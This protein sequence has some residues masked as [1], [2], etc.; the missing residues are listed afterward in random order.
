MVSVSSV[1]KNLILFA[2]SAAVLTVIGVPVGW[3]ALAW[4]ALVPFI[5]ACGPEEKPLR[6]AICAIV[7]G[8]IYW[9]GNLY[10][11]WYVAAIGHIGVSFYLSLYWGL[12]AIAVRFVRQKK[13]P[14]FIAA[15]ILWVGAE[16]LQ[17]WIGTG[18]S[19]RL[20]SHSQWSNTTLIQI[21]DIFGAAGISFFIA[22]VNGLAADAIIT[23]RQRRSYKPVIAG[24]VLVVTLGAAITYYGN[25]RLNEAKSTVTNGPLVAA[26]QSNVPQDVK[27]SGDKAD[28]LLYSLMRD[29][30]VAQDTGARLIAWPE[31]M[32]METLSPEVLQ[33]I[34]A[35]TPERLFDKALRNHAAGKCYLLVGA[36]GRTVK[37]VDHEPR[38]DKRYNSAFFYTPDTNEPAGEYD[39]IHLVPFGEVVPF[40]QSFP[41]L[42]KLLMKFTPYDY[43]YTLDYGESYT[44]F[45]LRAK[46]DERGAKQGREYRFGTLICYEDTVPYVARKFALGQ[47]GRKQVDWLVNISNDGWFVRNAGKKV[48]PSTELPQH[49]AISVFRA[50]ENRLPI[51]RS[52]NTGISCLVDSSGRIH[53][54]FVAASSRMPQKAMERQGM[55][56]WFADVMPVDSRVTFFSRHGQI[57]DW[58][59]AAGFAAITI[60]GLAANRKRHKL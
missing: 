43:D 4:V 44:V 41:P 8:F 9:L 60:C 26:V 16:T 12:L 49:A 52:V 14:L 30:T 5:L 45:K 47:D 31:T 3:Y 25:Y 23:V 17:A 27:E 46:S 55:S 29:S 33:L 11:L 37:W 50:V 28:E 39:K 19:W 42:Y 57:L 10:W 54:G 34:D 59:C 56:G 1:I 15:P 53:D 2:L 51:L 32:V 38:W 21:A 40:K 22:M 7:V 36:Y 58:I 20:L 6:L 24:L 35:N 13:W 48:I 18:F